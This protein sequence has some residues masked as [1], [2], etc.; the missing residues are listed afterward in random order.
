MEQELPGQGVVYAPYRVPCKFCG[1]P[2]M[3]EKT[4]DGK[5]PCHLDSDGTIKGDG[6]CP[7]FKHDATYETNSVDSEFTSGTSGRRPGYARRPGKKYTP[8]RSRGTCPRM[9]SPSS[10]ATKRSPAPGG[11]GHADMPVSGSPR[12]QPGVEDH[13]V[14]AS[15]HAKFP[16]G[17]TN[18]RKM[19]TVVIN[20]IT[21]ITDAHFPE[22][23]WKNINFEMS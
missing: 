21:E 20:R 18:H 8:H 3:F 12:G 14:Q 15:C 6:R 23:Y 11:L 5:F 9:E 13:D 22:G 10:I 1:M 17:N 7:K 19:L 2:F 4:Y 16:T